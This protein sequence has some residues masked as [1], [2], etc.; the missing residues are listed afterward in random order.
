[1]VILL[2]LV[3]KHLYSFEWL[4]S[5]KALLAMTEEIRGI[6]ILHFIS[7]QRRSVFYLIRGN[8]EIRQLFFRGNAVEMKC[9]QIMLPHLLSFHWVNGYQICP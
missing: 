7:W 3:L 2:T 5:L 8:V 6:G 4:G 1:M 9:C